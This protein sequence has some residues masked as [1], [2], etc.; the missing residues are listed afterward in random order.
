MRIDYDKMY[1]DIRRN[2]SNR[3]AND[4]WEKEK[5]KN[6]VR[7]NKRDKEICDKGLAW[8]NN[9]LLLEDAPLELRNNTNFINGFKKGERIKN[10]NDNLESLG[11]EW[12]K[13]GFSLDEAPVKYIDNPYFIKGYENAKNSSKGR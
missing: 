9:G 1:K 13:G 2:S 6:Y 10:I 3:I 8:F 4:I 12:F 5:K 11:E 7:P